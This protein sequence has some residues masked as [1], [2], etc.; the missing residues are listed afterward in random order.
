MIVEHKTVN[1]IEIKRRLID[2]FSNLVSKG[3]LCI[4]KFKVRNTNNQ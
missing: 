4:S 1:N 3:M 2:L